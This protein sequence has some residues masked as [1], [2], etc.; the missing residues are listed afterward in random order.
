MSKTCLGNGQIQPNQE[1][2]KN[3]LPLDLRK[4]YAVATISVHGGKYLKPGISLDLYTDTD[5]LFTLEIFE[6]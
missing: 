1:K 2:E 4:G 6:E 3:L 5:C